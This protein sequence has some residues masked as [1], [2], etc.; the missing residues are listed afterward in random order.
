ML[1]YLKA[2]HALVKNRMWRERQIEEEDECSGI[3]IEIPGSFTQLHSAGLL[4]DEIK[5]CMQLLA[6]F[7]DA[8][9]PTNNPL[10]NNNGYNST[11][12]SAN[13]QVR[14]NLTPMET[15]T[16]AKIF[17]KALLRQLTTYNIR[18]KNDSNRS[19]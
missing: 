7:N 6:H 5:D 9:K 16:I 13:H 14:A 2:L 4:A 19:S 10:T 17:H 15:I 18:F 12:Y 11:F 8:K 3:H 1:R